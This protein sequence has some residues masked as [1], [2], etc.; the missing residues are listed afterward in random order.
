MNELWAALIGALVGG[1][2]TVL[3]TI[4]QARLQAKQEQHR[5]KLQAKLDLARE[6]IRYRLVQ[7]R[8]IEPLNEI[9]I[10]FTDDPEA[11]RLYRSL[12]DGPPEQRDGALADLL[13]HLAK[14][15]ALPVHNSS[16]LVRGLTINEAPPY[17][18][19]REL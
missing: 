2:L 16:D 18:S 13:L 7:H 14:A 5:A 6:A 4:I 10:V 9:P 17:L 1:A 8:V 15:V 12:R 19:R 11:I 3:G